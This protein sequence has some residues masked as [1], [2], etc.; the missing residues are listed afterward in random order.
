MYSK[1]Y[2]IDGFVVTRKENEDFVVCGIPVYELDEIKNLNVVFI[3]GVSDV[4]QDEVVQS[5]QQ[6]GYKHIIFNE[7]LR[8]GRIEELD[9][10]PE[11]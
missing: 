3:I 4:Y 1:Q 11:E 2:K 10:I 9:I 6:R 7:G 8:L 5:L